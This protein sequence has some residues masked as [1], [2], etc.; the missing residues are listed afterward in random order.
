MV[1]PCSRRPSVRCVRLAHGEQR[2]GLRGC[3]ASYADTRIGWDGKAIGKTSRESPGSLPVAR[4]HYRCSH[5]SRQ[6]L[7]RIRLAPAANFFHSV[8]VRRFCSLPRTSGFRL[9]EYTHARSSWH[10]MSY[11]SYAER[12][13]KS[14]VISSSGQAMSS[15]AWSRLQSPVASD[16]NVSL[17]TRDHPHLAFLLR[18]PV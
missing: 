11:D 10:R 9:S 13:S 15:P 12:P 4:P 8:R 5:S 6:P 17:R 14:Q 3:G 7:L 2:M 18:S 16:L 1:V